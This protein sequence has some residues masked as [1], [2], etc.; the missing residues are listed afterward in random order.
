MILVLFVNF[1]EVRQMLLII[2]GNNWEM[3]RKEIKLGS[4][5]LF[6]V[7]HGTHSQVFFAVCKEKTGWCECLYM[8]M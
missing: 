5:S 3:Y 6:D 1:L 2:E 8:S 4:C 7:H